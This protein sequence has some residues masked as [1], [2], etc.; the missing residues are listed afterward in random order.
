[1]TFLEKMIEILERLDRAVAA[2]AEDDDPRLATGENGEIFGAP[3]VFFPDAG[4]PEI[5]EILEIVSSMPPWRIGNRADVA[6]RWREKPGV[7]VIAAV[8]RDW[9]VAAGGKLFHL[10]GLGDCWEDETLGLT[11][12]LPQ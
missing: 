8:N 11:E 6:G 2:L 3:D 1:M 10:C 12:I 5:P 4:L 9:I 7:Y